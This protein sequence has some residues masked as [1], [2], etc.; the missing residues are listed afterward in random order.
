VAEIGATKLTLDTAHHTW[1]VLSGRVESFINA[2]EQADEP[3]TLRDYLPPDPLPV[4]RMTLVELIKVDLEYRWVHRRTPRTIEEYVKEFPDLGHDLPADLIYEEYHVRRRVGDPIAPQDYLARFPGRAKE[5]ERLFGLNPA[6][7]TTSLCRGTREQLETIQSGERLDDFDL[8]VLLGK[9]AFASVYLARQN[10]MQRLVALKISAD[11]G[12]EP[13]TLAQLDHEHIVRVFDQRHLPDRKLRLLYMQYVSGGTLQSVVE[14]VRR[15][16]AAERTGKMLV[17]AVEDAVTRRGETLAGESALKGRLAHRPWPEVVCGLGAKLARALDHAHRHGVLHRDIKPANVLVTA[18]GSPKLA[19]FNIGFSSKVAGATPAA[20]FGGT[21]AY[22]SPEQLEACNPSHDRTPDSLDGKSD[23]YSLVVVLW[24]LLTGERPFVDE[25][26]AA[27]WGATLNE[28]TARRR[29]GVDRELAARVSTDWPPGLVDVLL[30]C[31]DPDPQ[32]RPAD[33]NEMARQLELCLAPKAHTLLAPSRQSWRRLVRQFPGTCVVVGTVLPN[34]L[35]AIFNYYY[36]RREIIHH[37]QNSQKAFEQIQAVI[38]AIAFP[39]GIVILVWFTRPVAAAVRDVCRGATLPADALPRLRRNCLRLGHVAAGISLT[40]WLIAAPAYPIALQL[41]VGSV[42][43]SA[44]VHFVA[45][46][47]LCGLIAAA[48]PFFI[49]ACL[50]VCSF[51]PALVRIDTMS[52][53]DLGPLASL[54]RASGG[55]LLLA[56]SVPMLSVVILVLIGLQARF[57]LGVLAAAGLAGFVMS[58]LVYRTLQADLAALTMI[59]AP[60]E[61]GDS[62]SV[63]SRSF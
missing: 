50:S 27:G 41:E 22:M 47:T 24:E 34:A 39:V 40:L 55:Y 28:M 8:L 3:P 23:L 59:A 14:I 2:W 21:V 52:H 53:E 15:T 20:Y 32:K 43:V 25:Q 62:T 26:L 46:L 54:S 7:L 1:T 29:D 51:Y 11:K 42:P 49:V 30:A 63:L 31:L 38:N 16:P 12:N 33:G 58:F 9:G 37:L 57:A 44:Y 36:N 5:L 56:A 48:Y 45:S 19:D 6:E 4:R 10:S 17:N 61:P 13:Q 60:G 18:D 35:A